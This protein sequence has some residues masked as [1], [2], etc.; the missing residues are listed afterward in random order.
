[1]LA[2]FA[3][4]TLGGPSQGRVKADWPHP[5]RRFV[6][7][8]RDPRPAPAFREMGP[9]FTLTPPPGRLKFGV[10]QSGV[11]GRA[12]TLEPPQAGV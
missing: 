9:H 2:V 12:P 1:M 7:G 10:Q 5:G 11:P 3:G 4:P 8:N 6:A